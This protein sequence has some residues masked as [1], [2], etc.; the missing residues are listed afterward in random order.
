MQVLDKHLFGKTCI[1]QDFH[2]T[3]CYDTT[4]KYSLAYDSYKINP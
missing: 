4:G 2:L 1:C 3:W